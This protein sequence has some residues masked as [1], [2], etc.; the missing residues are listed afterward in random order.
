MHEKYNPLDDS[1][2]PKRFNWS[3][4]LVFVYIILV[5]IGICFI[6][7]IL[8]FEDIFSH[9]RHPMISDILVYLALCLIFYMFFCIGKSDVFDTFK[10]KLLFSFFVP[11]MLI[12]M[13]VAAISHRHAKALARDCICYVSTAEIVDVRSG[14]NSSYVRV[15]FNS[16]GT[17]RERNLQNF[18]NQL[19]IRKAKVGNIIII[20]Y[21]IY[22][23]NSAFIN[24]LTDNPDEKT[25]INYQ[26][27]HVSYNGNY[28][29]SI[30]VI[31]IN[32]RDSL[33]KELFEPDILGFIYLN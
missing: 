31:P 19:D 17:T 33:R 9:Y 28:Y 1:N 21:P 22:S 11:L 23:S 13:P 15:K 29:K 7:A 25:K 30:D 8:T 12:W 5:I 14:R 16:N 27:V 24:I 10:S 4:L 2:P 32:T 3:I 18:K 6:S 20:S 26:N